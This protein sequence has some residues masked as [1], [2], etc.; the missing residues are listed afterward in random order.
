VK[1]AIHNISQSAYSRKD[2]Y[3]E[4]THAKSWIHSSIPD[5]IGISIDSRTIKKKQLFLAFPGALSDGRAFIHSAIR[6][7]CSGVLWEPSNFEWNN[8]WSVPNLPVKNLRAIAGLLAS[9]FFGN[10]SEKLMTI[11]VTGTNGKTSVTKWLADALTELGNTC[12]SVGTLGGNFAGEQVRLEGLDGVTTPNSIVIQA[13]LQTFVM[14]NAKSAAIEV[15]SHALSQDR[16]NGVQFEVGVFT[17]LSR[18][19]LDY[20]RD[21]ESY[22]AAKARLFEY[23]A[24][25]CAV[26]NIDD[27]FGRLL[28]NQ[29]L[30]RQMLVMT[31]G[32]DADADF[33]AKNIQLSPSS[34]SF[35]LQVQSK[36]YAFEAPISGDFNVSN[37]LAVIAVLSYA[38]YSIEK[39]KG[40]LKKTKA[41]AGRLQIV[42]CDQKPLVY[43][44]YAHT[45]DALE[46]VL[47][48]LQKIK[49]PKSRIICVFGAGGDRD[50]EKRALMGETVKTFSDVAIVTNDN[51]RSEN[52]STIVSQ[53]VGANPD[54][55]LIELD[56]MRAIQRAVD[57]STAEDLILVA[58]KGHEQYQE[59]NGERLKFSDIDAVKTALARRVEVRE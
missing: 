49:Q 59:I 19:H 14:R 4:F 3:E 25:R 27:E 2:S 58:G 18:D 40:V 20:H 38:G 28:A 9:D 16:V 54:N 37:L 29:L 15:S 13:I 36:T 1:G 30:S 52:P 32:F 57:L 44:D 17:N 55:F 56:R 43:V 7:G 34:T 21:M 23:P 10:P 8:E 11:G 5:F 53:I 12:G 24:M 42:E 47:R 51:P 6:S 48:T 35:E 22:G 45:P 33:C 31:Y 41:P 46:K 39:I 26:I 50:K